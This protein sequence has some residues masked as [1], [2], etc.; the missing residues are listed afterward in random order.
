M[1][2]INSVETWIFNW[3]RNGWRRSEY[4][5]CEIKHRKQYRELLE[6]MEDMDIKWVS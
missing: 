5:R 2:L 6:A 4:G 3:L 1:Y